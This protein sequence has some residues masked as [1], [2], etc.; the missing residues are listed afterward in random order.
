MI[1]AENLH[2]SF[3]GLEVLKGA[4][5]EVEK[6]EAV[7]L[8]GQSGDG[9]T[10]L[11]KHLAGLLKPDKGRVLVEGRDVGKMSG[12][13]LE[14]LRTRFGFLFQGGALFQSMTV[15][16]NV[17]FPLEEKTSLGDGEIHDKVEEELEL[18]GLLG[19]EE[20]YPA[21]ISGGMR[22]RAALARAMVQAPEIM[23]FDEP[24]TGL[25]PIIVHSTHDLI[26]AVHKRLGF[27]ALIVSHAIPNIF[28]IVDRVALLHEGVIRFVGT[29]EEAIECEDPVVCDFIRG[30]MPPERY[31]MPELRRGSSI[32]AEE[33]Q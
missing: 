15:Y 4:N 29:P 31:R 20:K 18:V 14:E 6:G 9:K 11:L 21:E 28:T 2:K 32:D 7:A 1:V 33:V 3:D 26:D 16:E 12:K 5:L 27:T 8:I 23:F 13:E 19:S 30:S 10:V 22:K 24:T 17:A 25:D